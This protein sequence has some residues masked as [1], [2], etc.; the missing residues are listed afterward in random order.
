MT[1]EEF[2]K[3]VKDFE[4]LVTNIEFK[5]IKPLNRTLKPLNI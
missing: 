4:T 2:L 3:K 1:D 5:N